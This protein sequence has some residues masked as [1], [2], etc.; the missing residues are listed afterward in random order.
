M[1]SKM[2]ALDISDPLSPRILSISPKIF[3]FNPWPLEAYHTGYDVDRPIIME[4]QPIPGLPA[5]QRLE[6]ALAWACESGSACFDGSLLCEMMGHD[7]EYFGVARLTKLTEK[8]ATFQR[9]GESSTTILQSIF[10]TSSYSRL[11]MQNGLLYMTSQ[12]HF[13]GNQSIQA[14]AE[15]NPCINVFDVK[16][17][18]APKLVGHFAAPGVSTVCPLPDGRAIVGGSQLWLVGPP[19]RREG[20]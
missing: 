9:V 16:G 13:L 7:G 12:A 1:G 19:P 5:Q 4:L 3:S 10:G 15:L 2:A 11:Q 8:A 18:G 6:A 20:H 17:P 14:G